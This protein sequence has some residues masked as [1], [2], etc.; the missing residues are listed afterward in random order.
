L[1]LL[2]IKTDRMLR[3]KLD[4]LMLFA[5]KDNPELLS[6]YQFSRMI[7]DIS[8]THQQK[9]M[10]DSI[11]DEG[12]SPPTSSNKLPDEEAPPTDTPDVDED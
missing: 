8:A 4:N 12:T 9:E 6:K 3:E 10:D 2:F 1:S 5:A 7:V 11:E